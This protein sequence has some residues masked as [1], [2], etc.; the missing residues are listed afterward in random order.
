M[1]TIHLVDDDG[2]VVAYRLETAPTW[3]HPHGGTFTAAEQAA[4]HQAAAGAR[5]PLTLHEGPRYVRLRVQR[6]PTQIVRMVWESGDAHMCSLDSFLASNA[7]DV[8]VDEARE[9]RAGKTVS[10]GGGA[11]PF[12]TVEV[13]PSMLVPV[14]AEAS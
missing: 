5:A 7:E 11:R 13:L 2:A 6:V 12:V 9:L 14:I 3:S 1:A 8:T 10:F 4:L